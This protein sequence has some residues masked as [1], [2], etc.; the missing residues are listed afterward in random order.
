MR[1]IAFVIGEAPAGPCARKDQ[2]LGKFMAAFCHYAEISQEQY[3]DFFG[4]VNLY[5][6]PEDVIHS[7]Y[8]DIEAGLGIMCALMRDAVKIGAD[9]LYVLCMGTRASSAMCLA[10]TGE[11]ASAGAVSAMSRGSVRSSAATMRL[12][13][14]RVA[15]VATRLLYLPH[16]SGL[17]RAWNDK[18][19]RLT[20][21]VAVHKIIEG[22][23]P[24]WPAQLIADC[25][26]T[27]A[28]PIQEAQ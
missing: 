17:C 15:A 1:G 11:D 14:F 22:V 8:E 5:P 24:Y 18:C 6:E 16:P 13:E 9:K 25:S 10:A 28:N 26:L 2:C 23:I 27:V 12:P 19:V 7:R 21:Q 3:L 20:F 4:R